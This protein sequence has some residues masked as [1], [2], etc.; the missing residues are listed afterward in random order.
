VEGRAKEH[1]IVLD[2]LLNVCPQRESKDLFSTSQYRF[3]DDY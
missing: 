1:F 2:Q 3:I